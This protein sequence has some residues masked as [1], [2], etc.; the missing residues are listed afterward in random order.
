VS[1][2]KKKNPINGFRPHLNSRAGYDGSRVVGVGGLTRCRWLDAGSLMVDVTAGSH[3]SRVVGVGILARRR[4]LDSRSLM[5]GVTRSLL[6]DP[7]GVADGG[8][9]RWHIVGAG[10]KHRSV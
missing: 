6:V 1:I 10:H 4:W 8:C 9:A 7:V 2:T 5:V 3:G